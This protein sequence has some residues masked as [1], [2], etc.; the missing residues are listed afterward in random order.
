M[1]L[2][3][4]NH[5]SYPRIGSAPEQQRYRQAYAKWE[6][7]EISNK[8]FRRVQDEVTREVIGEQIK[9]GLNLV[10]DGQ[11]RWD[12]PISHLTQKLRGCGINGLLR[13]FD[14]NFYFRQPVLKRKLS[15][16]RPIL[17]REFQF[18]CRVSSKPVKPVIAG[19]YTLGKL[20]INRRETGF[21]T[22][23]MEFAKVVAQEVR[24]LAK[25]GAELIQ[26]EE[27]AILKYPDDFKI[28]AKAVEKIAAAKGPADLALYTYFG[29]VAPLYGKFLELPVDVL[30]FDF[31]YSARLPDVISR[32]GCNKDIG[33]G[34]VDGRNTRLEGVEEILPPLK[35]VLRAVESEHV[36][37]SPSCGLGDYLPRDIAFKKLQR[38]AEI[39][40][41]ARRIL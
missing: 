23:V 6:R 26:V 37:L 2:I 39:T 38:A 32:L 8:E 13:F 30:G 4:A 1:E 14:T 25:A 5:S 31:T 27:P 29:D 35:S 11:V 28:F 15:R 20:S 10:T 36:Y 7:K 9:A 3:A 41:K 19:P 40:E 16:P 17:K 18:A 22:I 24:D 34:I 12:D 33:L 21:E